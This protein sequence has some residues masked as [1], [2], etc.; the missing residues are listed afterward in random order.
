M[1]ASS[2]NILVFIER[3]RKS[4]ILS[5]LEISFKFPLETYSKSSSQL[6][7]N[8]NKTCLFQGYDVNILR[9]KEWHGQRRTALELRPCISW[10]PLLSLKLRTMVWISEGLW[11]CWISGNE[12]RSTGGNERRSH[13]CHLCK[14]GKLFFFTSFLLFW[15]PLGETART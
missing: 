7:T 14:D 9:R 3:Q 6:A 5:Y 4:K 10:E 13:P 2:M 8:N 15:T 12:V 11:S 1:W